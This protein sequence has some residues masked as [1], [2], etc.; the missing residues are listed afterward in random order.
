[1]KTKEGRVQ[2]D[3][4]IFNAP[5][6]GPL[7]QKSS[8]ARFTRTLQI[9]LSSGVNLIDAI[10]ICKSTMANAVLEDAIGTVRKSVESGKNLGGTLGKLNVFPRMA[11]QMI[12]VGEA[13]GS[14]DKMLEKIADFYEEEVE[15]TINGM[16]KLI[17]PIILIFL[18]GAVGGLL[19]A[20]YLPIFKLA[21]G[22][23]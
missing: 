17:E 9:M 13:T 20:M 19:I 7:V 2:I 11:V 16:T 1:M 21:G 15:I 5:L 12:S 10:D 4:I 3:R 6:F 22:A 14:L 8:I 18:G 23:G